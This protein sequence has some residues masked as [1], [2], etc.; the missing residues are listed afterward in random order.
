MAIM[1]SNRPKFA[2]NDLLS[3]ITEEEAQSEEAYV[4]YCGPSDF[5]GET[6]PRAPRSVVLSPFSSLHLQI[7]LASLRLARVRPAGAP[8][9]ARPSREA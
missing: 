7:V 3:G 1:G 6:G 5:D 9:S 4:S 2:A 8:P